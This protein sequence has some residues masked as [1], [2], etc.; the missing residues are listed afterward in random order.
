MKCKCG[1]IREWSR[2]QPGA[3]LTSLD[4]QYHQEMARLKD[5]VYLQRWGNWRQ[6]WGTW[7]SWDS[8]PP[9]S[10]LVLKPLPAPERQQH[11]TCH[12]M[13]PAKCS[14]F[15]FSCSVDQH[16]DTAAKKRILR[17]ILLMS[18]ATQTFNTHTQ[19]VHLDHLQLKI[20][21]LSPQA[22]CAHYIFS[23]VPKLQQV[24]TSLCHP[25]PDTTDLSAH[26]DNLCNFKMCFH[27][28]KASL[29][30]STSC[31]WMNTV[32]WACCDPEGLFVSQYFK[33]TACSLCALTNNA[34]PSLPSP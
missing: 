15:P 9:W 30:I 11:Q 26:C 16:S 29:P 14:V 7:C 31:P 17:E 6:T 24:W 20:L 3:H 4:W 21:E 1:S 23:A 10:S 5:E 8:P 32:P 34:K 2:G 28:Q 27:S 18:S 33:D 25:Q 22:L 12:L 19:L 13:N